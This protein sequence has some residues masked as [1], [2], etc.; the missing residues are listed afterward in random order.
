MGVGARHTYLVRYIVLLGVVLE[1]FNDE[2]CEIICFLDESLKINL[3]AHLTNK[4][5]NTNNNKYRNLKMTPLP[6]WLTTWQHARNSGKNLRF[7]RI[8]I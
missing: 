3:Y 7:S 1:K 4:A 5:T 6:K 2:T 8:A